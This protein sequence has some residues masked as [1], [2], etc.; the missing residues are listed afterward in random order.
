M[1]ALAG[2]PDLIWPTGRVSAPI[3]AQELAGADPPLLLDIRNPREWTARHIAG[4]VDV[5]LN[6]LRER[7][8]EIPRERRIA[9]HCAGGYRYSIAAGILHQHGITHLIE[10]AGGPAAWD[11]ARRRWFPKLEAG[12][13][14][15]EGSRLVRRS[16]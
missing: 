14:G 12:R 10:R 3:V 6:H 9:V 16:T 7:P 13:R 2:R 11:A 5:P 1:K 8:A 15:V 4:S